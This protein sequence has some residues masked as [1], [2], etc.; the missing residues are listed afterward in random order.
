[1]ISLKKIPNY[2]PVMEPYKIGS[3]EFK[4]F[5]NISTRK[6]IP[7]TYD[8]GKETPEDLVKYLTYVFHMREKSSFAFTIVYAFSK[9]LHH[10][11]IENV[12]NLNKEIINRYINNQI[13]PT[14][15]N[16][17]ISSFEGDSVQLF[18]IQYAVYKLNEKKY[19]T[20]LNSF[21]NLLIKYEKRL[22]KLFSKEFIPR[23]KRGRNSTLKSFAKTTFSE[24]FVSQ[25]SD[26]FYDQIVE[27]FPVY[28]KEL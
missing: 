3:F 14:E 26:E 20:Q 19:K 12:F 2:L 22:N 18:Q 9:S 7:A 1:M 23:K 15:L 28:L 25:M 4:R 11:N 21:F 27:C 13:S 6:V 17:Y 5:R 16:N 10:P 8:I 24:A